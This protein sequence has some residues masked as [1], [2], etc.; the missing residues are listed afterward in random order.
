[1]KL[2]PLFSD[3]AVLQRDKSVPVWGT[4]K[5]GLIIRATIAG[6]STRTVASNTGFFMLRF[7]PLPVGGPYTLEITTNDPAES[8]RVNDVLVGEVWVCSG[9]SNMEMVVASSDPD[10]EPRDCD[11]V[12]MITVTPYATMCRQSDFQGSWKVGKLTNVQRF[13]AAGYYFAKKLHDELGVPVGMV[14]TSWG[15]TRIETWISRDALMRIPTARQKVVEAEASFSDDNAWKTMLGRTDYPLDPGNTG[16]GAGWAK[17]SFDDSKWKSAEVPTSFEACNGSATNGSF[18]FR[19]TVTIPKHWRGKE[20]LLSIGSVDKH[21]VTYFNGIKVGATG[22]GVEEIHWN[23]LRKY[24][25]PASAVAEDKVVIAVRAWSFIYNG[26]LGG[27]TKEM[28]LQL[29]GEDNQRVP[30]DGEWK[31][32]LEHDIGL[33]PTPPPA[34]C[35]PGNAN[36]PYSLFDSM[37]HPLVPYAIRGA[38][39][40]QGE[41]N[42]GN[43]RE[44]LELQ[45]AMVDDWRRA[46]GQGDFPYICVQLANFLQ[47]MPYDPRA[48]WPYV[49]EAQLQTTQTCPNTGMA[50]AIDIGDAIDIH[51]KNKRDVGF[52]LAQWA[53]ARTYQRNV[54]ANGPHY[55]SYEI[56]GSGVRIRFTDVGAGLVIRDAAGIINTC[57]IADESRK[58]VPAKARIEG[59]TLVVWADTVRQPRAVRYAWADNPDGCNLYNADGL[60]A[61]PFRTDTW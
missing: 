35:L 51:P 34:P 13:S 31:F 17:P 15:G 30:L 28:F 37:I 40:Y 38:I 10:P 52:R 36:S 33:T 26:A 19:K 27:P 1:M 42:A 50:S 59:D 3:H 16:E 55:V 57:Y 41:S 6:R 47:P 44:Y 29:A 45:C 32:K 23:E 18:W 4:T 5:P 48:T 43:A 49:R 53:L 14:H 9:Q 8:A 39:W 46:W 25:V 61:S 11:A 12:R 54:V 22:T 56:E 21:D 58:F 2:N 20:L 60:P 24:T 7:Q